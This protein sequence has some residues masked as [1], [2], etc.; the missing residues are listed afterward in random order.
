[1]YHP[2]YA[3]QDE[4]SMLSSIMLIISIISTLKRQ[5]L[6]VH[7]VDDRPNDIWCGYLQRR[8]A[9]NTKK[10]T[11]VTEIPQTN[12]SLSNSDS[13]IGWS[14]IS[15]L[16]QICTPL[17]QTTTPVINFADYRHAIVSNRNQFRMFTG[18]LHLE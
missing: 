5:L 4:N 3:K 7:I 18:E 2:S 8:R 13:L 16:K 9:C 6:V 14:H 12:W 11:N 1:M 10:H 15:V 17:S